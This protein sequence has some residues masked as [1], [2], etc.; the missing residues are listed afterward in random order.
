MVTVSY[1][2]HV[3]I[4][5]QIIDRYRPAPK[6]A[7]LRSVEK[8]GQCAEQ[9]L[10]AWKNDLFCCFESFTRASYTTRKDRI[11]RHRIIL[12]PQQGV[13]SVT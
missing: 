5:L 9:E 3:N 8:K 1:N 6:D 7:V 13:R 10:A 2:L 12:V 4:Q 11:L